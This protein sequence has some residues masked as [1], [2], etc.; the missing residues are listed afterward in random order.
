MQVL[1]MAVMYAISSSISSAQRFIHGAHNDSHTVALAAPGT[2]GHRNAAHSGNRHASHDFFK[3]KVIDYAV[4]L[5]CSSGN[6]KACAYLTHIGI[7]DK[8]IGRILTDQLFRNKFFNRSERFQTRNQ[9]IARYVMYLALFI[10]VCGTL[11]IALTDF[12][13]T[14][15]GVAHEVRRRMTSNLVT[16]KRAAASR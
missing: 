11:M 14:R 4:C 16:G 7:D 3:A 2:P 1:N 15:T 13:K 5:Q 8:T 12:L 6:D 10:L 9:K